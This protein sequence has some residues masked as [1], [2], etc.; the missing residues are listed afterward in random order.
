MEDENKTSTKYN[1][2]SLSAPTMLTLIYAGKTH[3]I[4]KE[5]T[6]FL[7]GRDNKNCALFVDTEFASRSHCKISYKDKVFFLEDCSRNGT[8]IQLG[9]APHVKL[10]SNSIHLVGRGVFKLGYGIGEKDLDVIQ[11]RLHF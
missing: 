6:P 11:F 8:Y 7:I 10:T 9:N 5:D 1:M 3:S 2:S 4:Y